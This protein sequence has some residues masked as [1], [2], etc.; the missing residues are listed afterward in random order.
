[1]RPSS[2][3]SVAASAVSSSRGAPE[4]EAAVEVVRPPVL[5][6]RGHLADRAQ[7][8]LHGAP[9][10]EPAGEQDEGRQHERAEEHLVLEALLR[11]GGEPDDDRAPPVTGDADHAQ[12]DVVGA[13]DLG[14][15]AGASEGHGGAVEGG[16]GGGGPL[17][18]MTAV[19]HPGLAVEHALVRALARGE[20]AVDDRQRGDLGLGPGLQQAGRLGAH[21]RAEQHVADH[22]QRA[23]AD[24]QRRQRRE[25][26]ACPQAHRRTYPTPR[27]VSTAAGEPASRSLR[28]MRVR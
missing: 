26:Q 23:E 9:R 12:A 10:R 16:R 4:R 24:G 22:Q 2:P 1:M 25:Q 13:I 28:R 18:D 20:P 7:R 17:D 5:G 14:R 27:T 21:A 3:S 19:Q 8:A 15:G 11:D 6:A